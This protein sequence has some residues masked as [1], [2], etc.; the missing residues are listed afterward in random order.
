MGWEFAALWVEDPEG[1][2]KWY[3]RRITDDSGA[4]VEQSRP[5]PALDDCVE[6]AKRNGFDESGCPTE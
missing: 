5:F 2:W 4:L 1:A 3:W 6:D